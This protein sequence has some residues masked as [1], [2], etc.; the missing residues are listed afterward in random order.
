MVESG[1][2]TCGC[3]CQIWQFCNL[4]C[5]DLATSSP[6][7][8]LCAL[9]SSIS[10][11]VWHSMYATSRIIFNEHLSIIKFPTEMGGWMDGWLDVPSYV[12]EFSRRAM[13]NDEGLVN[14]VTERLTLI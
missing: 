6:I 5:S 11:P 13:C 2:A 7:N 14:D 1:S 4:V 3:S 8:V 10:C 12:S 9:I